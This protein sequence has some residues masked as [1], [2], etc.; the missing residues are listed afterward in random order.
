MNQSKL[1]YARERL[2]SITHAKTSAVDNYDTEDDLE[3]ED[4]LKR[5]RNGTATINWNQIGKTRDRWGNGRSLSNDIARQ[6]IGKDNAAIARR[7]RKLRNQREAAQNKI[8]AAARKVED[9]LVLG[10]EAK[11]M[12][13]LNAF[14]AS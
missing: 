11:A 3:I 1:K 7:N 4:A 8:H 2:R 14:A 10:D 12:A 9:E 6:V 5:L 13:L